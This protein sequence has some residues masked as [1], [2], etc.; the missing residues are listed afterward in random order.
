[1]RNLVLVVVCLVSASIANSQA[2]KNYKDREEYNLYNDVGKDFGA[3]NFNKAIADLDLWAQKYPDSEFKDD[4]QLLYVQ[5]YNGANQPAKV[6]DSAVTVFANN[7]LLNLHSAD[8]L[9]VLYAT[10]SAIQRI[11]DPSAPQ[12]ATAERAAH[13]LEK[14]DTAPDGV[15]AN[16]WSATRADL[17]QAARSAL[18]LVAI[19]PASRA[20][21]SSDCAAGESAALKAIQQFPDSAQAAWFLAL[22]NV[23]AAKTDPTKVSVAL[24]ELARAAA[25]DASKAMVDPKWQQSNAAPYLER[26]YT[27]FH[28]ADPDGLKQLK[29]LAVQSPL[30][31]AGFSIKSAAAV[32]RDQEADFETKH[33]ELALWITIREALAR[34]DGEVYFESG[35]KAS[36]VPELEGT[37]TEAHPDCRPSELHIAIALPGGPPDPPAEITL[38]LANRL[39]GKPTLG[40]QIHWTGVPTAFSKNPFLLTMDVDPS[41]LKGVNLSPCRES[42]PHRRPAA[43]S[44]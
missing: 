43:K 20:I 15:P 2:Q 30:P 12:L 7:Q 33:P 37:L 13:L 36:A 9:R 32:A 29:E 11:S 26:V 6:L 14:F 1:M 17:L 25:L 4:R 35:L 18:L 16:A 39:T 38:K 31:P 21:K 34:P 22:A 28:G 27:Q 42:P 41:S 8:M 40:G 23:C 24:Y 5:A 3:S 10:V 44:Q 19:V